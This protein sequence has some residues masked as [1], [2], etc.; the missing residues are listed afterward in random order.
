MPDYPRR[1]RRRDDAN[2]RYESRAGAVAPADSLPRKASVKAELSNLVRW[3][4][5]SLPT[6]L[7]SKVDYFVSALI[8]LITVELQVYRPRKRA[9]SNLKLQPHRS[10][11]RHRSRPPLGTIKSTFARLVRRAR[12][13]SQ[14]MIC[15]NELP[16]PKLKRS[17]VAA[18][19]K[20]PLAVSRSYLA[21]REDSTSWNSA[22]GD[23][24]SSSLLIYDMQ[25]Q[26]LFP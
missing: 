10:L 4:S 7:I 12:S 9:F 17:S 16:K 23:N 18:S 21:D 8:W 14:L 5:N 24:V 19:Q 2:A 22:P 15:T 3:K 1:R 20:F 6:R 26:T 11:I 25:F 13:S